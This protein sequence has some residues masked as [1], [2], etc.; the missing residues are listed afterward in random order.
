MKNFDIGYSWMPAAHDAY[1]AWDRVTL[2]TGLP[3]KPFSE[4]RVGAFLYQRYSDT[5]LIAHS[6]TKNPKIMAQSDKGKILFDLHEHEQKHLTHIMF[7]ASEA[8]KREKG[9]RHKLRMYY[10]KRYLIFQDSGGFQLVSGKADFIDPHDVALA[11]VRYAHEGVG[12]DLPAANIV[13]LDYIKASTE[14]QVLNNRIIHK[15]MQGKVDLF[16]TSHGVD[17]QSRKLCL[18]VMEGSP[19]EGLCIAG[20]RPIVGVYTPTL[21]DQILH[22]LYVVLRTRKKVKRY[23]VLGVSTFSTV[24]LLAA[25]SKHLGVRIT[26]DSARHILCGA[27]GKTLSSPNLK[28]IESDAGTRA[29]GSVLGAR[30]NFSTQYCGCPT[31]AA[32]PTDFH[33][34]D[35]RYLQ[36]HA[37]ASL[38]DA[39]TYARN[40]ADF[41]LMSETPV[42]SLGPEFVKAIKLLKE[43]TTADQAFKMMVKMA[44][45]SSQPRGLFESVAGDQ[46]IPTSQLLAQMWRIVDTYKAYHKGKKK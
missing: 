14:I 39:G 12:L 22:L 25:A 7:N 6:Y 28:V 24:M 32:L 35:S 17:A 42:L 5:A 3:A 34:S 15:D 20:L 9:K 43:I 30:G 18:D 41:L 40:S 46:R 2:A 1:P 11:H 8:P 23:H 29:K 44:P 19:M 31:C 36:T 16:A 33:K 37:F 45:K 38:C 10:K 27:G 4:Q 13:D 21:I 26:S